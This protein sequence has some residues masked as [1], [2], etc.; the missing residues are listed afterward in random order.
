MAGLADAGTFGVEGLFD[1]ADAGQ[2]T[3]NANFIASEMALCTITFPS[4][5]GASWSATCMI[6]DLQMGGDLDVTKAATFKCTLTINGEPSFATVPAPALTGLTASGTSG[7]FSPSF[8]G[9]TMSYGYDFITSTSI[10]FTPTASESLQCTLYVDGVIQGAAFTVGTA[11][12]AIAFSTAGSH[13]VSLV[14]SGAGYSSQTY[15]ITAVRTT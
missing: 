10:A 9:S 13:L 5:V 4:I 14:I 3:L 2:M 12:P 6:S 11:S 7:T 1:T 15:T 8:S